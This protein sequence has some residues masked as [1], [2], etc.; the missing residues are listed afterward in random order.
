MPLIAVWDC[1]M[2]PCVPTLECFNAGRRGKAG[3][4]KRRSRLGVPRA[5]GA[6]VRGCEQPLLR[7]APQAVHY[8]DWAVLADIGPYHDIAS[9]FDVIDLCRIDASCSKFYRRNCAWG[10]AWQALGK[11]EFQGLQLEEKGKYGAFG[12]SSISNVNQKSRYLYFSQEVLKF[13][14]PFAPTQIRSVQEVGDCAQ[15]RCGIHTD[16]AKNVGIYIEIEVLANPD[17]LTLAVVDWE[18]GGSS[19]VTFSPD[20][21]MV[22]FERRTGVEAN[23]VQGKYVDALP[24]S[25]PRSR[26][27]GTIGLFVFA[28]RIAFFRRCQPLQSGD[29]PALED[30]NFKDGKVSGGQWESTGYISDFSWSQGSMLIP[31]IAFRNAGEYDV[32]ISKVSSE[33]PMPLDA[34]QAATPASV[35]R[36]QDFDGEW[37]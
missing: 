20:E 18:G 12:S 14:E 27:C 6:W 13:C 5:I 33:P 1:G 25:T 37:V 21:G 28:G 16:L 22:L 7:P 29:A 23:H 8:P 17:A 3:L 30:G 19:S 31:C 11:Q 24:N 26:F 15:L 35:G 34:I 32:R 10:G 2:R 36:W 9:F 4:R